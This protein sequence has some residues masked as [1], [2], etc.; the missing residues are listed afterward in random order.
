LEETRR[1]KIIAQF[2]YLN[3]GA[4]ENRVNS[5][6]SF[7]VGFKATYCTIPEEGRFHLHRDNR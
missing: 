5:K 3:Q 4:E 6:V 2:W 1:D 7:P